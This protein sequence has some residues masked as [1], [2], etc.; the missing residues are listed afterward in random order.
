MATELPVQLLNP[1]ASTAGQAVV[2]TGPTTAPAWGSP[3]AAT[4]GGATFASPPSTGY[5]STTPEPVFATTLSA[6]GNDVLMY[7]NTAGQT[8][9]NNTLTTVTT[10]TKTFD[11]LSA[12]FNASTGTFTA[13]ATGYYHID[14]QITFATAVGVVNSQY[15]VSIVANGV[16]VAVPTV[17]Q[18]STSTDALAVP[19]SCDVS[20]SAGQTLL[21]QAYQN[22]GASRTLTTGTGSNYVSINRIP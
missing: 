2:S 18:Q 11:R 7:V 6:V 14:G 17:Y 3:N 1:A 9:A 22:T 16:S 20:L 4:L 8:V 5:G 13:P 19:F 15:S 12:N 21:I 10:W